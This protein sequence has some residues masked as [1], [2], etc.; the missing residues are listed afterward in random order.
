MPEQQQL[1]SN[2]YYAHEETLT[3]FLA[4]FW[5]TIVKG[6]CNLIGVPEVYWCNNCFI[7]V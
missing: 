6:S 3:F 2:E 4:E 7:S 5:L 1:L